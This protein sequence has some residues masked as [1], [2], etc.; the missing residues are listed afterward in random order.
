VGLVE[1]VNDANRSARFPD[2]R[3]KELAKA[4]RELEGPIYIH[5]HHGKHRSPA[6]ASVAC[7]AAGLVP[8]SQGVAILELAGTSPNYRGLY[9]SARKVNPLDEALLEELDVN[10]SETSTVPPMA[11]NR[12]RA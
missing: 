9:E 8:K 4:V 7:V 11:Q 5:C 1:Q 3:V 10:F 12:V 2:D 6:A